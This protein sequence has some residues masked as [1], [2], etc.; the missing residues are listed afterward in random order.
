MC[1]SNESTKPNIKLPKLVVAST[2][3]HKHLN[4]IQCQLS[5]WRIG[6][7][8][9]FTYFSRNS[10]NKKNKCL[11][12][13]STQVFHTKKKNKAGVGGFMCFIHTS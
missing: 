12:K 6:N 1:S 2:C 9:L 5:M 8:K 3:I 10:S 7:K 11:D 13:L 4:T